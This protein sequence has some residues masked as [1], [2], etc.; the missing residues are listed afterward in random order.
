MMFD[1][2]KNGHNN[3][4]NQSAHNN[5]KLFIFVRKKG[6]IA[7]PVRPFPLACSSGATVQCILCFSLLY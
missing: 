5:H 3:Q 2:K 1:L 6:T 7:G 4:P